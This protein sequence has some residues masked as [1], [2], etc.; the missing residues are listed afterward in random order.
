MRLASDARQMCSAPACRHAR[1]FGHHHA[2]G[3]VYDA[4]GRAMRPGMKDFA[5]FAQGEIE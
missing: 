3:A 4:A 5:R 2:P 1:H